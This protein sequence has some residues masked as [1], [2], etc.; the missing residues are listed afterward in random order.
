MGIK[1]ALGALAFA[2]VA[3]VAYLLVVQAT[4]SEVPYY[5]SKD[6]RVAVYLSESRDGNTTLV[7]EVV[8]ERGQPVNFTAFLSGPTME[9]F[10]DIGVAKGKGRAR[11][12]ISKYV[13]EAAKLAKK[14]GYKPNEVRFGIVAFVT[15]VE[16]EG[17][18]TYLLTDIITIP[19]G[20]GEAVGREIV[21]KIKFKPRFKVKLNATATERGVAAYTDASIYRVQSEPPETIDVGC[22]API[23]FVTCYRYRVAET[24]ASTE[25]VPLLITYVDSYSGNFIENI[26]H[27]H[28][29][30]LSTT[31]TTTLSFEM[32]MAIFNNND[33][34]IEAPGPGFEIVL[35]QGQQK[36]ILDLS[37]HFRPSYSALCYY[38]TSV[39]TPV[40]STFTGDALLATGLTGDIRAVK[41]V[42]EER[43]CYISYYGAVFCGSWSPTSVEAWGVWL[44]G[45]WGSDYFLP[46]AEVDD[47]PNDGVGPLD[48]IYS[49]TLELFAKG[50]VDR[51]VVRSL[52]PVSYY[53]VSWYTLAAT[54]QSSTYFQIALPVGAIAD[55]VILKRFGI[56]L[57][58]HVSLA[59]NSLSVGI[60]VGTTRLDIF[61]YYAL[62]DL[63][64]KYAV[65]WAPYY[66]EY[67]NYYI[68]MAD[69]YYDVPVPLVH[70]YIPPR[71]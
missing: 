2:A 7:L 38:G 19:V 1:A 17:N 12:A 33:F 30:S 18:D 11:A 44:A 23:G 35:G 65:P 4:V 70:A 39:F 32:S 26:D 71:S 43:W 5:V 27:K 49:S 20:P 50:K 10:E 3:V 40:G 63:E 60:Y 55:W 69:N 47:N 53:Y 52:Y 36:K 59:L 15:T 29:I 45:I 41:Y 62:V 46:Y 57:P 61:N 64:A 48:K 42:L 16:R 34:E 24:Y 68:K 31:T 67:K 9:R 58:P 28:Y 14:L 8:D 6:G 13:A 25:G 22:T 21:A 66:Y 54:S 37:C 56:V 51:V